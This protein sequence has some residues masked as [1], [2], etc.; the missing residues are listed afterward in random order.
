MGVGLVVGGFFGDL[1]AHLSI[2]ARAVAVVAAV[3]AT[4][5]ALVL[6]TVRR[7]IRPRSS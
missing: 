1:D 4:V 2:G 3:T 7:P 6:L 5:G